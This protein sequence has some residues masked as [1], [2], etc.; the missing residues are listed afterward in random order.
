[1]FGIFAK[2]GIITQFILLLYQYNVELIPLCSAFSWSLRNRR[3]ILSLISVKFNFQLN[4]Q[5]CVLLILT[6]VNVHAVYI[7]SAFTLNCAVDS[8]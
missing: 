7:T 4:R 3:L 6:S 1:M 2:C 5:A 8:T